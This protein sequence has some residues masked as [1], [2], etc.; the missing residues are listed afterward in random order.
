MV[1]PEE[2]Y[3]RPREASDYLTKKCPHCYAYLPLDA[4]VCTSCKSRVGE[5]DKLGFAKKPFDWRGYLM[6]VLSIA[7]L[8]VF[9]WW[10]FF[11][12]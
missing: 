5:V 9:C 11:R 6:A 1:K 4:T 12:Q 10:A 7:A 8:V 2:E 3:Y